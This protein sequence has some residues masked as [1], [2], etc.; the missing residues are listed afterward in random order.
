MVPENDTDVYNQHTFRIW[1]CS[2]GGLTLE[3]KV[4]FIMIFFRKNTNT[5]DII[6]PPLPVEEL[7]FQIYHSNISNGLIQL[8][9]DVGEGRHIWNGYHNSVHIS[10]IHSNCAL[11]N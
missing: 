7:S 4:L 5:V 9:Y 8:E 6:P 1:S 10:T 11:Q 3:S 2:A